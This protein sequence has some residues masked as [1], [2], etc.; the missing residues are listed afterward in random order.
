MPD[1]KE[2]QSLILKKKKNLLEFE[3]KLITD[4]CREENVK[5]M[6]DAMPKPPFPQGYSNAD[7]IPISSTQRRS[8]PLCASPT[9][10]WTRALAKGNNKY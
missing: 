1:C 9:K 4:E 10:E 5:E 8:L 2:V 7:T 6:K 3:R